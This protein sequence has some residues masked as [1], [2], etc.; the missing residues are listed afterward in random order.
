MRLTATATAI[1]EQVVMWPHADASPDL[2]TR[3]GRSDVVP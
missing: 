3:P 2:D 1:S